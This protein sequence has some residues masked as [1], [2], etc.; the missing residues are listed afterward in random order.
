MIEKYSIELFKTIGK[1]ITLEEL[2]NQIPNT[3]TC[4]YDTMPN[5]G[6]KIICPHNGLVNIS[7][8][9][10]NISSGSVQ[11]ISGNFTVVARD[12]NDLIN[13]TCPVRIL[14]D[15]KLEFFGYAIFQRGDNKTLTFAL[16][17]RSL[18]EIENKELGNGDLLPE[19]I[20][21]DGVEDTEDDT[22]LRPFLLGS[23][24]RR[25]LKLVDSVNY[26]YVVPLN[27]VIV[28]AYSGEVPIPSTMVNDLETVV[29][30]NKPL[31]EVSFDLKPLI[32]LAVIVDKPV[33]LVKVDNQM[34][35][36]KFALPTDSNAIYY[37]YYRQPHDIFWRA[38]KY[39]N[40]ISSS[41]AFISV[42]GDGL[43]K[44]IYI[45]LPVRVKDT[46]QPKK[47][48]S[49][50]V[51]GAD[52]NCLTNNTYPITSRIDLVLE[53]NS[54]LENTDKTV[55]DNYSTLTT[56]L[57]NTK[58]TLTTTIN[59][60]STTLN[61]NIKSVSEEV[62]ELGEEIEKTISGDGTTTTI[63]G[64]TIKLTTFSIGARTITSSSSFNL[65]TPSGMGKLYLNS[66]SATLLAGSGPSAL[67]LKD[68]YA[69]LEGGSTLYLNGSSVKLNNT[70]ITSIASDVKDRYTKAEVDALL[71]GY[72]TTTALNGKASLTHG[73]GSHSHSIAEGASSTGSTSV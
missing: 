49:I 18:A 11:T 42:N 50:L 38:L 64:S 3:T 31:N 23:V 2:G 13:L 9:T 57:A 46:L 17:D 63:A 41:P 53:D 43:S 68:G 54:L 19:V 71:K 55:S 59:N 70:D 35:N 61:R 15:G 22:V 72:A 58:T 51:V 4:L 73:H 39:S 62:I 1:S 45:N 7:P 5:I 60:T 6:S 67:R 33:S 32:P 56:A 20:V 27:S 40:V 26:E 8:I 44:D 48:Y 37:F 29:L 47:D 66:G 24:F 14:L 25:E 65:S 34:T 36:F 52:K 28:Q 30:W 10:T 69:L 16:A 12:N 21:D